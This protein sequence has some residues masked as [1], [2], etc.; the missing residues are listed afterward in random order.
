MQYKFAVE[1]WIWDCTVLPE[2]L[3]LKS[4]LGNECL[5]VGTA[6]NVVEIW[7]TVTRTRLQQFK[8]SEKCMLYSMAFF[9][10]R[11][12]AAGSHRLIVASGTVF[13]QVV[14]WEPLISVSPLA[15]L[16]GHDGVIWNVRWSDDGSQ[17]CSVSDD[18]S[19][20]V[21]S[22]DRLLTSQTH[23]TVTDV[24]CVLELFGHSARVWD[25]L[26][27]TLDDDSIGNNHNSSPSR[28]VIVTASEDKTCAIWDAA[29]GERIASMEG[30]KGGVWKIACDSRFRVLVSG[31]GD[32]SV[33]LWNTSTLR[34][35]TIESQT[36]FDQLTSSYAIP[37]SE[38][39]ATKVK[40]DSDF[41]RSVTYHTAGSSPD[42]FLT[43]NKGLVYRISP[44]RDKKLPVWT[45]L[46][47]ISAGVI[48]ETV[49]VAP[50]LSNPSVEL[51][52]C[53]GLRGSI[54]VLNAQSFESEVMKW[55][56][57]QRKAAA[58]WTAP[59]S[60]SATASVEAVFSAS[61]VQS[62]FVA[63]LDGPLQWWVIVRDAEQRLAAK[64]LGEYLPPTTSPVVSDDSSESMS[65]E[66]QDNVDSDSSNSSDDDGSTKRAPKKQPGKKAAA[67]QKK[68][69]ESA[70][71]G[72][73]PTIWSVLVRSAECAI[74]CGDSNGNV[75]LF[76]WPP[77]TKD[78]QEHNIGDRIDVPI[79]SLRHVHA[80][81]RVSTLS[82]SS[83]IPDAVLS[84]GRDG[85][86]AILRICKSPHLRL[87]V[88][89]SSK[90]HRNMEFVE[91]VRFPLTGPCAFMWLMFIFCTASRS[92]KIFE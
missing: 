7:N 88:V 39:A 35:A 54:H 31:A 22:V 87:A 71:S 27:A 76:T 41:V 34:S 65:M 67:K 57:G 81:E 15:R 75:H 24:P 86:Y 32:C 49:L 42:L 8:C 5:A 56:I 62:L 51:L 80:R 68:K 43:T 78:I 11:P 60:S 28:K 36:D 59:I 73:F 29:T 89:S 61:L 66:E 85:H 84:G 9:H 12:S 90:V 10:L 23:E 44:G 38:S 40:K 52:F 46:A 13:N 21:W 58:L 37:S 14:I 25:A 17:I 92:S 83:S 20:R 30:H 79:H 19:A 77:S 69:S 26:F 53:A 6:H 74:V 47:H 3:R 82:S 48:I 64:L 72:R 91:K 63:L 45:N 4:D 16:I 2:S 70:S 1:D 50:D 18:R 33:R 55:T